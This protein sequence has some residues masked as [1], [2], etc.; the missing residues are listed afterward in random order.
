MKADLILL[1][2]PSI[3]DFRE[4][5][6]LWGPINDLVPSTPV[7]EMYPIGFVSIASTLE[8]HGYR[9]RI[10]NLALRMLRDPHF[11]PEAYIKKMR[12]KAFGIDLHWMPH[13]HGAINLAR[14]CKQVHEDVPVIMGGLS[15][16]YF[17]EELLTN[18]PEVDFVLRGDSTEK[19]FVQLMDAISGEGK[20]S[21]V[22]NLSYREGSRVRVNPIRYVPAN[23]D[24]FSLDY[25]YVFKS[26]LR[27]RSL[28]ILP[29]Y[30]FLERPIMAVLTRKGCESDCIACGGSKYAYARVCNRHSVAFRKPE[31]VVKD[32][33]KIQ[34]F[35]A[36]A[37]ILGD[38]AIGGEQYGM[39]VLELLKKEKVD[40]PLIFEFFAPPSRDFM[41]ELGRSVDDFTIEMSPESGDEKVREI[42]GRNYSNAALM[43]MLHNAFNAGCRQFD[44]YF[45]IGLGGQTKESID[46]TLKLAESLVKEHRGGRLLPFI[47]PYAPF[48]DPGSIAYENPEAYGFVKYAHTL[49]DHYSLLDRGLTWKDF[50][51]YRTSH[52]S[53]DDIVNL[54]YDAALRLAEIKANAGLIP[55]DTLRE[56]EQR[57]AISKEMIRFV[58]THRM[59]GTLGEEHV[60][61]SLY[62]LRERLMIDRRELDW[63]Q[64]LKI[65]RM[66]ALFA[67]FLKSIF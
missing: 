28:D 35:K 43:K 19:P 57:I 65:K 6:I 64:G 49:M 55:Q 11:D 26:M 17:H 52:L 60:K 34:E 47:S 46:A 48:L 32:I 10:V 9:V 66:L 54:S 56:I 40:I 38:L 21:D 62:E 36:P 22:P 51:S 8:R 1:H 4:R 53:K 37:F 2:P 33:L 44:L 23:L 41:K 42:I 67:K 45:M 29:F 14:L 50:L 31:M 25:D 12:A 59:Q 30:E 16:S 18:V 5:P 63:S 58:D 24:E 7:F 27:T 61:A 15:S 3:F 13:V 39:K 20:L